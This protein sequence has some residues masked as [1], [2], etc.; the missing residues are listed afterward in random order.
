MT[1]T[2]RK[3]AAALSL[4]FVAVL[5]VP[6]AHSHDAYAASHVHPMEPMAYYK[7][8]D[9]G[10]TID[11][12]AQGAVPVS[13]SVTWVIG[14]TKRPGWVLSGDPFGLRLSWLYYRAPFQTSHGAQVFQQYGS[15]ADHDL[16]FSE[17]LVDS[18][19]QSDPSLTRIADYWNAP[20]HGQPRRQNVQIVTLSI[21]GTAVRGQYFEVPT[22][23]FLN[24]NAAGE[25]RMLRIIDVDNSPLHDRFS[26]TTLSQ[27]GLMG[28]V[29]HITGGRAH[30]D[31]VA[32]LQAEL[33]AAPPS[34][35]H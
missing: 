31:L 17:W 28:V 33:D 27:S 15:P 32:H 12:I 5:A 9:D 6:T 8:A 30:P 11:G 1:P 35:P 19:A 34:T 3:S 25:A 18:Q 24:R 23:L 10:T 7:M 16:Y 20:D 22:R 29:D 2:S 21:A 13:P 26:T 4:A 14:L